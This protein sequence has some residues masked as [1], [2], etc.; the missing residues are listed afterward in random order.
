MRVREGEA[1]SCTHPMWVHFTALH[2]HRHR[3]V[4]Q[5]LHYRLTGGQDKKSAQGADLTSDI[6]KLKM[7]NNGGIVALRVEFREKMCNQ[8]S[9]LL[10][11]SQSVHAGLT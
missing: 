5:S 10:L 8:R 1:Y 9:G 3:R 2:E 4:V 11:T 6:S 7:G